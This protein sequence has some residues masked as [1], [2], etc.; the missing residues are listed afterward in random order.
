LNGTSQLGV[1]KDSDF[2]G[3]IYHGRII[4][5]SE[6][7]FKP[8]NIA[9]LTPNGRFEIGQKICLSISAYH[10]EEWQ[11]S[12]SIRTVLVALIGFMPTK[13]G[14]AIG[15]MD[16]PS[17]DRKDLAKKSVNWICPKCNIKNC[18]FLPSESLESTLE[19]V[20]LP[21]FFTTKEEKN[22]E[23][24]KEEIIQIKNEK[25][26]IEQDGTTKCEKNEEI[27]LSL[28]S[29]GPHPLQDYVTTGSTSN[30]LQN[31]VDTRFREFNITPTTAETKMNSQHGKN[32]V[33]TNNRFMT[34][35]YLIACI[36]CAILYL[37]FRKL[38]FFFNFSGF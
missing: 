17:E 30:E 3:G 15:A 12:W 7:P 26:E 23:K 27:S 2:E 18:H 9:F 37:V 20:D 38:Y 22:E 19:K 33:D 32:T 6:Y 8:P 21:V 29:S 35:D 1:K 10:P 14:G 11:P 25:D 31:V 34:L 16:L 4:L 5:P 36:L 28:N 13:G 24:T